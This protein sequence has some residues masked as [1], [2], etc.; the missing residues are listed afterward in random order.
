MAFVKEYDKS[1]DY[2]KLGTTFTL[3]NC[4]SSLYTRG[5]RSFVDQTIG[6]LCKKIIQ[7]LRLLPVA[8]TLGLLAF[9]ISCKD[10]DPE[11]Q[12]PEV[13][14]PLTPGFSPASGVVGTAVTITGDHFATTASANMV[15][16]N[17]VAATVQSATATQIIVIVPEGATTGKI[18]VE[19]D[20]KSVSSSG[21]FLISIPAPAVTSVSP[22]Q[23]M[24]GDEITI[25]GTKFSTV[26]SENTVTFNNVT[27]TVIT[28]MQKRSHLS[29]KFKLF[30]ALCPRRS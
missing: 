8:L 22:M 25:A 21:E 18:T 6:K 20:G 16:F 23:G 3:S 1:L 4:S 19:V 30:L 13:Q 29:R 9:V 12:A 28:V 14:P 27:A 11:V 24:A 26:L 10:G 5:I 17:G 2:S 15:K 7:I